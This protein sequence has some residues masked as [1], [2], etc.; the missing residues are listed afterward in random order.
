MSQPRVRRQRQTAF[1]E[2]SLVNP[3]VEKE[4]EELDG[5]QTAL[6]E[7]RSQ[8]RAIEANTVAAM[9]D[10][11]EEGEG[12]VRFGSFVVDRRHV[13]ETTAASAPTTKAHFSFSAKRSAKP[14]KS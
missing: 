2:I 5:I 7:L 1:E 9:E 14:A 3:L 4:L 6:A 11:L 10:V 8:R 13:P 12:K